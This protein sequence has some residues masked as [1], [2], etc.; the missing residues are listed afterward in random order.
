MRRTMTEPTLHEQDRGRS[1]S[2]QGKF[3]AS[4]LDQKEA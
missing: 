4:F 3:V 2:I 1:L